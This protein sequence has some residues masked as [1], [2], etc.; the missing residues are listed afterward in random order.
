MD[1]LRNRPRHWRSVVLLGLMLL[2]VAALADGPAKGPDP[3]AAAPQADRAQADYQHGNQPFDLE[4]LLNTPPKNDSLFHVGR[5]PKASREK[6]L[7]P[8]VPPPL[9]VDSPG[10]AVPAGDDDTNWLELEID[11]DGTYFFLGDLEDP[12][13]AFHAP[14]EDEIFPRGIG[15]EKKWHF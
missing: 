15:L 1:S 11:Q 14:A 12:D 5:L 9:G 10:L 4:A 8:S 3:L 2:P 7:A 6:A 13:A